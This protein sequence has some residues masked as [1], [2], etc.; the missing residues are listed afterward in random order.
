MG[1]DGHTSGILPGSPSAL[2]AAETLAMNF[3]KSEPNSPGSPNSF[4]TDQPLASAY[5]W[6]DYQRITT[7]LAVLAQLDE[8]VLYA[9]GETKWPMLKRLRDD[10]PVVDMPVQL[11]KQVK[12][13]TVFTDY[14]EN[15]Q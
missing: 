7:T 8:A 14:Q 13:V 5:D 15:I 11:L 12:L 3:H 4:A 6:S 2:I 1:A 10:V 9:C